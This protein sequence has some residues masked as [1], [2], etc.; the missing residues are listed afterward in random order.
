MPTSSA[1][2]AG[3][4]G[5]LAALLLLPAC[6]AGATDGTPGGGDAAAG[7]DVTAAPGTADGTGT[8]GSG[9]DGAST[10]ASPSTGTA[11]PTSP[12]TTVDD[13]EVATDAPHGVEDP[14]EKDAE[15]V[16]GEPEETGPAAADVVLT[17]SAWDAAAGRIQAGGYVTGVV[18]TG[19]TC[20]LTLRSGGQVVTGTAPAEPDAS[21]TVCAIGVDGAGLGSGTWTAVLDYRSDAVAGSSDEREVEVP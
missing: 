4:L 10:D 7:T 9:T 2:R 12:I 1:Q 17:W 18:E 6:G 20:T 16:T 15:P 3:R 11:A 8:D 5:L 14:G 13:T 19:G 21:T